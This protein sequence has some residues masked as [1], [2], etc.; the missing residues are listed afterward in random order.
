[1]TAKRKYPVI[2]D[3]QLVQPVRRGYRLACCDCGLVH[4]MD[5]IIKRYGRFT[6]L[7]FR[8]RRNMRA[9]A[10]IRRHMKAK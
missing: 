4:D 10:A 6:K 9:T 5:F 3:N 1:M 2:K 8:A 7:R